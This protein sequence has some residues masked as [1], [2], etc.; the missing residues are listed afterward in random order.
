MINH[1]QR[2]LLQAEIV[3]KI[4]LTGAMNILCKQNGQQTDL[5][6]FKDFY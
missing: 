4:V 5:P 6:L 2:I 3:K 1:E